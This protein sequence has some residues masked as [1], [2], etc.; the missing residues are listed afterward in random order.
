MHLPEARMPT[1][2]PRITITLSDQ[3]H[4]TLATLAKFQK[5]SMSSIVVDLVETTL[6]VLERLCAVL[7]N[8][9]GAPQAVLD[10]LKRSAEHAELDVAAMQHSVLGHLDQLVTSSAAPG[11]TAQAGARGAAAKPPTSNRGVSFTPP[12]TKIGPISSKKSGT[13]TNSNERAKK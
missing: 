7:E 3:Q 11:V 5:C 4:A 1:A 8:A 6:P 2:K 13:Y 9:A 10:E 12:D